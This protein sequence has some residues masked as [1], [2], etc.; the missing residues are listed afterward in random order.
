MR[1]KVL[2][3][4]TATNWYEGPNFDILYQANCVLHK[5]SYCVIKP[6]VYCTR[7]AIVLSN[8]VKFQFSSL[9]IR[10]FLTMRC[11]HLHTRVA[12]DVGKSVSRLM[13]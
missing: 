4:G 2:Q 11:A 12:T 9:S 6:T 1:K 10:V 5:D 7:T 8:P 3:G 13:H